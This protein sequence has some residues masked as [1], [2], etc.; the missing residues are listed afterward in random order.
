M[1][2]WIFKISY[3][4]GLLCKI[5]FVYLLFVLLGR[6]ANERIIY[7]TNVLFSFSRLLSDFTS[8]IHTY[9]IGYLAP[10]VLPLCSDSKEE[11]QNKLSFVYMHLC[12]V[13][14][15]FISLFL[16]QDLHES[17]DGKDA[18]INTGMLVVCVR[19]CVRVRAWYEYST[20]AQ[21]V[22]RG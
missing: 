7:W 6:T 16:H 19:A 20:G 9:P 11:V 14:N 17:Q 8:A 10:P 5:C 1:L 21:S 22:G 13:K 15:S 2:F 12:S 4:S 18:L 3:L